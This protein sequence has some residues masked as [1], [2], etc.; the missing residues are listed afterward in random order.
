MR[1]RASHVLAPAFLAALTL[2]LL[3]APGLAGPA[4]AHEGGGMRTLLWT[5]HDAETD[6][7]TVSWFQLANRTNPNPTVTVNPDE[8]IALHLSNVGDRSHN[9][10]V[11]P[12]VQTATPVVEPGNETHIS[13]KVPADATGDFAYYDQEHREDGAEGRFRV[14][15]A[16][17]AADDGL[18]A[19]EP[20]VLAALAAVGLVAAGWWTGRGR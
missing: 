19:G 6:D 5:V 1:P 17:G 3:L 11:A 10:R 7:G 16:G 20:L 13:M 18:L 9:L 15:T 14:A 8:R 12:P 4:A 2:G